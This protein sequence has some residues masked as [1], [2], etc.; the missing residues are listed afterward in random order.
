MF[1]LSIMC[2]IQDT[3]TEKRMV[4]DAA[5]K[6][7]SCIY[8]LKYDVEAR[9]VIRNKSKVF[10]LPNTTGR[11]TVETFQ[12]PVSNNLALLSWTRYDFVS[13]KLYF[14]IEAHLCSLG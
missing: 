3:F 13:T 12:I 1:S 4:T 9:K 6:I 7:R 10:C 11:K 8:T 14:L 2:N 5:G